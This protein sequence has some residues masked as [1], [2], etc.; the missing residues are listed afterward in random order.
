MKVRLL[1]LTLGLFVLAFV[2]HSA[3]A[4]FAYPSFQVAS[5]VRNQSVTIQTDHLPA[6]MQFS[7]SFGP[8][9]AY[10]TGTRTTTFYSGAGG[11]QEY[12]FAIPA[13]YHGYYQISIRID[14]FVTGYYA[15]NWFYNNTAT[16]LPPLATNTPPVTENNDLPSKINNTVADRNAWQAILGWD[17]AY[18]VFHRN[19]P[20]SAD[21]GMT[22]HD[23]GDGRELVQIE[24]DRFA[25]QSNYI[26]MVADANTGEPLVTQPLRFTTVGT[27]IDGTLRQHTSEIVL[28]AVGF[29]AGNRLEV[30]YKARGIGDCGSYH[31]YEISGT[32][33]GL[34]EARERLCDSGLPYA[35]PPEWELLDITSAIPN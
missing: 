19:Q 4:H 22:F 12:T 32:V 8:M 23:L 2:S 6:N 20:D 31:V 9:G 29:T 1:F 18:N 13:N 10:G 16:V 25:Y 5:V 33:T 27:D 17:D 21:G 15:V 28:G 35:P 34:T 14:N 24:S 7:V 30:F 26:F 11:Q 3:D